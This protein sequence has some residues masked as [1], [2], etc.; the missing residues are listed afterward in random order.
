MHYSDD[1]G[2]RRRALCVQFFTSEDPF[3]MSYALLSLARL[4][5]RLFLLVLVLLGATIIMTGM[6]TY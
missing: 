6:A 5:D 1:I 3:C 2:G 4:A